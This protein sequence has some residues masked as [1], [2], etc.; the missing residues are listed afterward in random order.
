MV[1]L[2]NNDPTHDQHHSLAPAFSNALRDNVVAGGAR[3]PRRVLSGRLVVGSLIVAVVLVSAEGA[4]SAS[5]ASRPVQ[6]RAFERPASADDRLTLRLPGRFEVLVSRK[7]AF[8]TDGRGRT[9]T[10]YA[11]QTRSGDL[12]LVLTA[13][14][15]GASL[16]C[17][18]AG[19]FFAHG[20]HV[21]ASSGRLFSG[22][23][24]DSISRVVL[25]GPRGKRHSLQVSRDGGFIYNCRAYNGCANLIACIEAYDVSGRLRSKQAW[26]PHGCAPSNR[27]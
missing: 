18:P 26:M 25:V 22:V 6:L 17:S 9:S 8:Y 2:P 12:C 11:A 16:G 5:A 4:A 7:I 21:N 10:L 20:N 19:V 27:G 24:T 1:R 15:G 13:G 3:Y 23:T 14:N